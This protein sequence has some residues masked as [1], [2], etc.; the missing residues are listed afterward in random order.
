[1]SLS[2][3]DLSRLGFGGILSANKDA[4]FIDDNQITHTHLK[5]TDID[6]INIGT[7]RKPNPTL[8]F[9]KNIDRQQNYLIDEFIN[10]LD[11]ENKSFYSEYNMEQIP[12]GQISYFNC[13]KIYYNYKYNNFFV[14]FEK[15]NVSNIRFGIDKNLP[16]VRLSYPSQENS[17]LITGKTKTKNGLEN[18]IYNSAAISLTGR[19]SLF[20]NRQFKT[21]INSNTSGINNNNYSNYYIPYPN[22][23]QTYNYNAYNSAVKIAPF[24][25]QISYSGQDLEGLL[26]ITTGQVGSVTGQAINSKICYI[27]P[28]GLNTG[29]RNT[30]VY[31]TGFSKNVYNN[32]FENSRISTGILAPCLLIGSEYYSDNVFPTTGITYNG[33]I[34]SGEY[35]KA[36]VTGI[37]GFVNN[38]KLD[39]DQYLKQ[40]TPIKDTLYYK[41]YSGLYTGNKT[42]NTGVWD[43]IIPSGT[44]FSIELVSLELNKKNGTINPL[45]VVYSGFGTND[46]IDALITKYMTQNNIISGY[47]EDTNI[48]VGETNTYKGVGR[49][50]SNESSEK[51]LIS[52]IIDSRYKIVTKIGKLLKTYVPQVVKE[53][54]K[55]RKLR[56]FLN[57]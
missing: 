29:Y 50:I 15:T 6:I 3:R 1:M 27:S 54:N 7:L 53:N 19:R 32:S 38:M 24:L 20:V 17:P 30:V 26:I 14:P 37:T 46:T 36:S 33:N 40:T 47:F 45:Y 43:G 23:L 10:V 51:S 55:L 11:P 48:Y 35:S 9:R 25:N 41:F 2:K 4:S 49:N 16:F 57:R 39:S 13:D 22:S 18:I 28:H 44:P 34:P 31:T 42:F 8:V 5:Q 21:W 56:K 52:A 12:F